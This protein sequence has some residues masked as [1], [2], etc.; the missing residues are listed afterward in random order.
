MN[1]YA[2]KNKNFKKLYVK[3][4][5]WGYCETASGSFKANY[6]GISERRGFYLPISVKSP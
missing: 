4:K 6:T 2:L 5:N 3:L 1:G